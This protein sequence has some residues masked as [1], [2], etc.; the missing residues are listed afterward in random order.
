MHAPPQ[1]G[2]LASTSASREPDSIEAIGLTLFEIV[3]VWSMQITNEGDLKFL[4]NKAKDRRRTKL[5]ARNFAN[6]VTITL[7]KT[8]SRASQDWK[9]TAMNKSNLVRK[10]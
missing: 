7:V 3:F 2:S 9:K 10:S 4:V 1:P 8:M 6:L 5:E